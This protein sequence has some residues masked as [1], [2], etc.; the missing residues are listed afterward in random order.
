[1][2][3]KELADRYVAVW[4]EPDT[5]Q[6]R[7]RIA[8]L[9]AE[10]GVH[11]LEPPLEVRETAATLGMTPTLKARG[12]DA[13]QVRVTRSYEQFIAPGEFVFRAR[14]NAARLDDV[15][16]FSWRWC[17][18]TTARC[19]AS[20]W[21]SLCWTTTTGSGSTTSS[22]RGERERG[23]SGAGADRTGK[24]V[25]SSWESSVPNRNTLPE[26]GEGSVWAA[27]VSGQ[28]SWKTVP[29]AGI[30][31]LAIKKRCPASRRACARLGRRGSPSP[32]G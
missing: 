15:V 11:I 13:L 17:A 4:I 12:H 25:V 22:S 10:D 1:M 27:W 14:D 21:R 16:K 18:P 5:E 29:G 23:C 19:R 9:W 24:V 28:V 30:A 7:K 31:E 26:T 32:I 20:A 3:P 6:R 2:D 8:Q